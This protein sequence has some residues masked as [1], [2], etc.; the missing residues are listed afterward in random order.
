MFGKHR[1]SQCRP[2]ALCFPWFY[3]GLAVE[4]RRRFTNPS[5]ECCAHD[6]RL[7]KLDI[8]DVI[9][10]P[11]YF[12]FFFTIFQKR[13]CG[14]SLVNHFPLMHLEFIWD[15]IGPRQFHPEI[16]RQLHGRHAHVHLAMPGP[17]PQISG[18]SPRQSAESAGPDVPFTSPEFETG[19]KPA[20]RLPAEHQA[21]RM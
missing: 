21:K 17:R 18:M 19:Y 2:R 13:C 20:R 11:D 10:V 3:H 7:V 8:I 5:T 9:V 4:P 1:F 14:R 15:T 16:H 12:P 6:M